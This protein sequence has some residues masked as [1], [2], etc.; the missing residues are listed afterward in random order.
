MLQKLWQLHPP[1]G[2]S[3]TGLVPSSGCPGLGLSPVSPSQA[4]LAADAQALCIHAGKLHGQQHCPCPGTTDPEVSLAGLHCPPS[5]Q[6]HPHPWPCYFLKNFLLRRKMSR[7][8]LTLALSN[9]F[10]TATPSYCSCS[11]SCGR[12]DCHHHQHRA[13]P[14]EPSHRSPGTGISTELGLQGEMHSEAAPSSS[15]QGSTGAPSPHKSCRRGDTTQPP[16]TPAALISPAPSSCRTGSTP[17]SAAGSAPCRS[18]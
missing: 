9:I 2:R 5:L 7:L 6:P 13:Q 1:A 15:G 10:M 16:H 12:G 11:R 8:T 3:G 17:G 18:P 14:G 4:P